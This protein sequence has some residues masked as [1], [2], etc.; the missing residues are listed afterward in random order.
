MCSQVYFNTKTGSSQFVKPR[1]GC[2]S[3]QAHTELETSKNRRRETEREGSGRKE[4]RDREEEKARVSER[5]REGS[6][7]VLISAHAPH[8][9][10][11]HT[12]WCTRLHT[13]HTRWCTN[14]LTTR[15]Q[16]AGH[17]HIPTRDLFHPPS[18]SLPRA[19][20]PALSTLSLAPCPFLFHC[21]LWQAEL[22][23]WEEN[24]ER[25]R[26]EAC[27]REEDE[28]FSEIFRE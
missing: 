13:A 7:H 17:K 1:G 24:V 4:G 21:T 19:L 27:P 23:L 15:A 28:E 9:H 2:P 3:L 11:P 25:R 22:A 12:R 20:S 5:P 10:T 14:P 16:A 8:T 26:F 18:Y 6:F